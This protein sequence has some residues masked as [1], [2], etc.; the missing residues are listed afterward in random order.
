LFAD[1]GEID[2]FVA[3]PILH[4]G[5]GFD[6]GPDIGEEVNALLF[7]GEAREGIVSEVPGEADS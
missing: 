7:L 5:E 1:F 2:V 3:E 4:F 6:D